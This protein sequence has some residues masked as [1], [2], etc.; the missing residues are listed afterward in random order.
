MGF[1]K[2]KVKL[3][4]LKQLIPERYYDRVAIIQLKANDEHT[5]VATNDRIVITTIMNYPG[6]EQLKKSPLDKSS[7]NFEIIGN[8]KL[9]V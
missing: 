2:V 6:F 7:K 5:F 3:H 1:Y 4:Y 9:A 8:N